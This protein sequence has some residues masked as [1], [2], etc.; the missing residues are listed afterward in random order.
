MES[1]KLLDSYYDEDD[2]YQGK[3]TSFED[4]KEKLEN[5]KRAFECNQKISYEIVHKNDMIHINDNDVQ[6]YYM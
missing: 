6:I 2:V 3:R 5:R 1:P 4:T